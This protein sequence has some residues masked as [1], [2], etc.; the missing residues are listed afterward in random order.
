MKYWIVVLVVLLL[1]YS[2]TNM[3]VESDKSTNISAGQK[4][5]FD[6]GKGNCLAC[7]QIK[8]GNL[9]GNAGPPLMMMKTRFPNRAKLRAQIWDATANNP[10]TVMPPF[11]RHG[12]LTEQEIDKVVDFIHSL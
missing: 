7:H 10:Q 5:A 1:G 3:A 8:G 6:R 4:L 2:D 12:I 9:A 11:G